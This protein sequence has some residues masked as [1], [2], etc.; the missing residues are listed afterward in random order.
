M[1]ADDTKIYRE[2]RKKN[3]QES[4]QKDLDSLKAWLDEW[5]LKFHPNK[6]YSITI[7][8]KKEDKDHTYHILDK[9]TKYNMAQIN[10]MKDIG[11]IMDSDL[12]FEKHINSKIDT[13]NKILGIIRRSFMY[14]SAEI[15]IPLYKAMVRSHFDYAMVIWNPHTVKYIETIEGVQ[16]RA[17]KM[18][19]EIKKLIIS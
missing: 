14:L 15:F 6:C 12:K 3:D 9:G 10:D 8:K 5:L 18:V 17:T 11:V 13:A 1:Y 4:L 19:P 16:R 2:I 7:G